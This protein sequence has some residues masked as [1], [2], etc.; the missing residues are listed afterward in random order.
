MMNSIVYDFNQFSFHKKGDYI[1]QFVYK[2]MLT[3][4]NH[5][6]NFYEI[7]VIADGSCT[8]IINEKN[9]FLKKDSF[10]IL[11]PNDR[12]YFTEQSEDVKV[13]SLSVKID[14]FTR[15]SDVYKSGL[16]DEIDK[17]DDPRIFFKYGLF[18]NLQTA[19]SRCSKNQS[20]YEYKA[21]LSS[22][23]KLY[24][25]LSDIDD[26][27]PHNLEK[28]LQEMQKPENMKGGIPVFVELSHY[29]RS[30]LTR[31]MRKHFNMSLHEYILN[32][33]LD[34]AYSDLILSS[35]S[36][37]EISEN[38]GYASFSHFN[39]IFKEKYGIT[40]AALRKKNSFR[41]V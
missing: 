16:K 26:A 20:E 2:K 1:F 19:C 29:S 17:D 12:H 31:L 6:H 40:P 9:Y 15:F 41:T 7:I 8:Q 22:I 14:E 39:K 4:I 27:L 36:M 38:L 5:S 13:V 23:I 28:A 3:D 32:L 37:E 33:R 24:I 35:Q 11:R 10:V 34:T 25:D 21:L 18:S 30:H